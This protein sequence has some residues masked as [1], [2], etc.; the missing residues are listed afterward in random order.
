MS[1][2]RKVVWAEGV[3]LGQQ[4]FQQWEQHLNFEHQLSHRYTRPFHWGL[5]EMIIDDAL[6]LQ[7]TFSLSRLIA[8]L[9]DS[10]WVYFDKVYDGCLVRELP[11]PSMGVLSIYLGLPNSEK[12]S[13]ISGYAA[14]IE[15]QVAWQGEYKQLRDLYDPTRE[16]EVLLGRQNLQL[17]FGSEKASA[18]VSFKIA[19]LEYQ[20]NLRAYQLRPGYI[21]PIMTFAAS[22]QAQNWLI[23]LNAQLAK[24]IHLLSE[25]KE[26]HRQAH[27]QMSYAG[28]VYFNLIKTL[29]TS[30]ARLSALQ[31]SPQTHPMD[32]YEVCTALLGELSAYSDTPLSCSDLLPY[33]QEKLSHLFSEIRAGFDEL[34]E[35]VIPANTIDIPLE[36]VKENYYQSARLSH[37]DLKQKQFCLALYHEQLSDALIEKVKTQIKMSAPS[38]LDDIVITFTKGVDFD[39]LASPGKDLMVKRHYHYFLLKKESSGWQDILS[40]E[41]IAFFV[42]KELEHCC[43]ELI[44]F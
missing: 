17:F 2:F 39:Y 11:E 43:F 7:G 10:R 3:M 32:V 30:Y 6:L 35:D 24:H 33:Q 22:P 40:E 34:M 27:H 42:S 41:R 1:G 15:A 23:D 14:P 36:K 25:Q 4:H 37:D 21:P 20:P 29:T 13:D 16:R 31:K 44:R 26:K 8:L 28:F 18:M 12:V 5:A 19:E 9:P 38:K